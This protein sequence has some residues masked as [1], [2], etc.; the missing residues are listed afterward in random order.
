[1]TSTG[2]K[3]NLQN[4]HKDETKDYMSAKVWRQYGVDM[5]TGTEIAH[6]NKISSPA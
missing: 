5:G 2:W 6:D 1:L 4:R 3:H